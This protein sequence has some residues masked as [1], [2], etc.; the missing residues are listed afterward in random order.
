MRRMR[1]VL[2][3]LALLLARQEP[4]PGEVPVADAFYP[5]RA[6]ANVVRFFHLEEDEP[7]LAKARPALAEL[8][9]EL[10]YGPRTESG[11]PGHAFVALR[12]PRDVA[13]KKLAAALRKGGG[14]ADELAALVFDGRTG[15]AHDFGLGGLGVTK[16]DFVMGMSGD[17]TWYEMVGERS[18]LFGP[19][20]TL[21]AAELAARYAKLYEPYGGSKLGAPARERFTWTLSAAPDEKRRAQLERALAK[22]DGVT[23]VALAGAELTVTVTLAD[24]TACGD[25]GA[26]PAAAEV[27]DDASRAMPRV[28]FDTGPLHALLQAE[29]LVLE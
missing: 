23:A 15:E 12:A 21:D 27:L 8:G 10:L 25:V 14:A 16:R 24:L 1:A 7:D 28:A 2:P 11:R 29:G 19:P 26:I 17:V 3:L 22:L 20:G 6:S 9:A 13:P 18:Q 4:A 5:C